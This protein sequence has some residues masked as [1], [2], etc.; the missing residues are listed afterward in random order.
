VW[1]L[2]LRSDAQKEYDALDD[3]VREEA[4]SILSELA[5]NPFPE[6]AVPLRGHRDHFR[7]RFHDGQ[8][9]LIYRLSRSQQKVVVTRIR[10]RN[11]G[12]YK[13]YEVD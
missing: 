1:K 8:Y 11:D 3:F 4:L 9:R 5:E 13:G 2:K 10:R 7:L 12:A 6:D